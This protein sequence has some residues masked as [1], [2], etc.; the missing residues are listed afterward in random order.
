MLKPDWRPETFAPNRIGTSCPSSSPI[1]RLKKG[2]RSGG[3]P[4]PPAAGRP[5]TS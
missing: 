4:M 5:A 2:T 3:G 1:V